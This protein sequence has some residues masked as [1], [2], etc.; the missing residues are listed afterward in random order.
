MSK[1]GR[2][3]SHCRQP[4][5]PDHCRLRFSLLAPQRFNGFVAAR[6]L[7]ALRF[8]FGGHLEKGPAAKGGG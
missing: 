1:A 3:F 7:S 8:E 6:V 4:L 2:H 5:C